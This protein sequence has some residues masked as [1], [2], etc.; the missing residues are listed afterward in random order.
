MAGDKSP[1]TE[2]ASYP[3]L[4]CLLHPVHD[5]PELLLLLAHLGLFLLQ[6]PLSCWFDVILLQGNS[7]CQ[8]IAQ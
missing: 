6:N 2:P 5:P 8:H 7:A 3:P 1:S 4:L